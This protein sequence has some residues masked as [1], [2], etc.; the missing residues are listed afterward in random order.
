MAVDLYYVLASPPC[1]AVLMG[2]KLIGIDLNLKLVDISRGEQ[3][4]PEFLK[5]NPKHTVPVLDDNGFRLNESRVM[6]T[7][8]SDKYGKDDSLYPKDLQ[9]RARI[10][11]LLYF[12]LEK[13]ATPKRDYFKQHVLGDLPVDEEKFQ[14][15]TKNFPFLEQI[16]DGAEFVAG[17]SLSVA[18]VTLVA[19]IANYDVVGIDLKKYPNINRWYTKCQQVIPD[20]EEING[21]G[22][23]QFKRFWD[24]L[25]SQKK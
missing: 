25:I 6:L 1:R 24:F 10:D 23:A 8:L 13:I 14:Q 3:M 18:D 21:K 5:I 19:D 11:Q 22:A 2:A 17:D 16:L 15:I 9:K 4:S 20:Y 12:D 7:Y